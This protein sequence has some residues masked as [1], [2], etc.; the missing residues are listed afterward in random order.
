MADRKRAVVAL[1]LAAAQ[2]EKLADDVEHDQLWSK[3]EFKRALANAQAALAD[4]ARY[5]GV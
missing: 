4:A 5:Y 3:D 2:S 1:R